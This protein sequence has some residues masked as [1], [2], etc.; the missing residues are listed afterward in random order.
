M[1]KAIRILLVVGI[2]L[3]SLGALTAS[4]RIILGF[5]LGANWFWG[6]IVAAY[7]GPLAFAAS[8]YCF[9]RVQP[10]NGSDDSRKAS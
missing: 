9:D 10:G 1:N 8:L 5:V 4:V 7:L 2:A 6:G 3:S